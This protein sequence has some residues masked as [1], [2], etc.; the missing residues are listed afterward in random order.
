MKLPLNCLC[1]IRRWNDQEWMKIHTELSTY[2]MPEMSHCFSDNAEYAYRKGWEWTQAL[3]GLHQLDMIHEDATALGVGVGREPLLFYLSDRVKH[4]IGTDLYGNVEWSNEGGREAD[5]QFIANPQLFSN[6]PF[7]N[8]LDLQNMSGTQ[9][10]FEDETFDFTWSLSSIEHFGSHENSAKAIQE[11]ARVTKKNGIVAI[12]T[13]YIITPNASSHP[14]YFRQSDLDQYIL[15]ASSSL[16]LIEPIDYSLPPLEWLIDPIMVQY[17]VHRLRHHIIL[18][19]GLNQ[20]TSIMVF[21][22]K[23]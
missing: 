4:V 16:E 20:W 1:D 22:R 15:S 18:N 7:R 13:E 14:E 9:L 3:Y 12:A 19:D 2:A 23:I 10:D 5:S 6:R 17:D 11:M 21:F 8:H